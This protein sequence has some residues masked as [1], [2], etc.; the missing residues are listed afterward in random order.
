MEYSYTLIKKDVKCI[1]DD[2]MNLQQGPY[3]SL[4]MNY[5]SCCTVIP[6][7]EF[8]DHGKRIV[9]WIDPHLENYMVRRYSEDNKDQKLDTFKSLDETGEFTACFS[10]LRDMRTAEKKRIYDLLNDTRNFFRRVSA[11]VKMK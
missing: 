5:R 2:V 11:K 4:D 3:D 6:Y 10:E 9:I 1:S 7:M 8:D